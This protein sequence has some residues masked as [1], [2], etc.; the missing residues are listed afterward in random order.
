MINLLK[1]AYLTLVIIVVTAICYMMMLLAALKSLVL[2]DDGGRLAHRIASL[3]GQW[4]FNLLPGWNITVSGREN[5][6]P[7][8]QPVVM[9][10]N[11]ESMSDICAIYF[12]NTQFRWLSKEEVFKFPCIGHAMRLC[13]YVPIPRG[14]RSSHG[15]AM[16]AS[17]DHIR[18]GLSMFFFPEGTRSETGEL[19]PFKAGAF[20]LARDLK[21][22][23]L[24]IALHGAGDL[25]RK[26]SFTPRAAAVRVAV[27]PAISDH[28]DESVEQFADRVRGI[29]AAA[30]KTLV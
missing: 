7:L 21:V 20:K 15:Q 11:H 19:R 10:A 26:G 28:P 27:L 18:A 6:P 13:K 22:P 23:V 12:L 16:E 3:W 29:I 1:S 8:D 14:D 25:L 24:P 30:H 4:I 2:G 17:A 9:V 5:L